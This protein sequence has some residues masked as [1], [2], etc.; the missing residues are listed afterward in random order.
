MTQLTLGFEAGGKLSLPPAVPVKTS[1]AAAEAI[2]EIAPTL[3]GKVYAWIG[4]R[5]QLGATRH[6]IAAGLK[7]KLQ[8]V[9]GRCNELLKQGLIYQTDETRETSGLGSGKVL[10]VKRA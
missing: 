4:G 9:C 1:I 6:E 3:R 8:T 7:L 2:S 5:G 10:R